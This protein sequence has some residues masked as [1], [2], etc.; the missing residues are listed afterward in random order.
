MAVHAGAMF[1]A[2]PV[3]VSKQVMGELAVSTLLEQ[4]NEHVSPTPA[5]AHDPALPPM[6]AIAG[7]LSDVQ[8]DNTH[9]LALHMMDPPV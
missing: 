8:G 7:H 1:Q 5:S 6:D 2:A 3:E 9:P 4:V